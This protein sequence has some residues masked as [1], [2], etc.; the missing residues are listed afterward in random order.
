MHE[1]AVL[2]KEQERCKDA[3]ELLHKAFEG[4]RLKLGDTHPY[5]IESPKSLIDLYKALNKP[6]QAKDWRAGLTQIEDCEE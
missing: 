6:E 3:E 5:T 1:L 4:R 2:H